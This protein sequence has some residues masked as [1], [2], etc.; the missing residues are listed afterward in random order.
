M[1]L[2]PKDG[3]HLSVCWYR[4]V[5]WPLHPSPIRGERL[6]SWLRR[7]AMEYCFSIRELLRHGLGLETF[8]TGFP[9]WRMSDEF[10]SALHEKTGVKPD[11][12][13]RSTFTGVLPFIFSEKVEPKSVLL[14][15]P[16]RPLRSLLEWLPWLRSE[17]GAQLMAC[18]A[19]LLHYP[20][21]GILLPWRLT[22]VLSCPEHGLMLE[23][24]RVNEESVTW[25][26][27]QAEPAPFLVQI[28]DY[29]ICQALLDGYVEL[30]GGVI[31]AGDWFKL[32]QTVQEELSRRLWGDW[33]RHNRLIQQVWHEADCG[34][35][36]GVRWQSLDRLGPHRRRSMLIATAM[37]LIE[38]GEIIPEGKDVYLFYRRLFTSHTNRWCEQEYARPLM[39]VR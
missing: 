38:R 32:M 3:G 25:L 21:A 9:D 15:L 26:N 2:Q 1:S 27:E 6:T 20:R 36:A 17:P 4:A 33:N 34:P 22:L 7:T 16:K 5:R 14:P 37:D 35:K 23:P 28:L 18:R 13:I 8:P 12:I 39:G 11:V 24:A 10:I 30:P 31:Q 29:R 19:C